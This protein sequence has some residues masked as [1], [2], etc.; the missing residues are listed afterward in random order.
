M[1][2]A[3]A[4]VAGSSCTKVDEQLPLLRLSD[5]DAKV[6]IVARYPRKE[7]VVERRQVRQSKRLARVKTQL[8]E[9]LVAQIMVGFRH[10]RLASKSQRFQNQ[11]F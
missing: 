4:M 8:S 7:L 5:P 10:A 3:R 11:K 9:I 2:S 6:Q 1:E